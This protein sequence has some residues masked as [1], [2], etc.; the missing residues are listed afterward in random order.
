MLE[1]DLLYERDER[2]DDTHETRCISGCR[3]G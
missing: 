2:D 1:D 3:R